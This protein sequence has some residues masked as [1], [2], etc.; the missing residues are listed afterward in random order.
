LQALQQRVEGLQQQLAESQALAQQWQQ[1]HAQL[2]D[3]TTR[4]VLGAAV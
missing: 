1:L 2:H 3:F 4:Q